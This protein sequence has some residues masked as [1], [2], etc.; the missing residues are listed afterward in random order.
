M[1]RPPAHHAM[2]LMNPS[3]SRP[4]AAHLPSTYQRQSPHRYLCRDQ[5]PRSGA[6]RALTCGDA[7]LSSTL[8]KIA[9]VL[10]FLEDSEDTWA[11]VNF[12]KDQAAPGSYVVISHVTDDHVSADAAQRAR[13]VYQGASAPGVPRTWG[14][15]ARFF[16][17]L[18][19]VPPGL[20]TVSRWRPDHLGPPA[21]PALFYAGIGCK[22]SPGRPR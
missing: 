22:T 15:I 14:Y 3:A 6:S 7:K 9:G 1:H 18:D 11:M 20:T 17:G 12:L 4:R 13:Q 5:P 16:G 8:P 19:L 10:H 21:G 2:P